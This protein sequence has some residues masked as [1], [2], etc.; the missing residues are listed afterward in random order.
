MERGARDTAAEAGGGVA[1]GEGVA[2]GWVG[3]RGRWGEG[4]GAGVAEVRGEGG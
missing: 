1:T 4:E 3:S 2:G